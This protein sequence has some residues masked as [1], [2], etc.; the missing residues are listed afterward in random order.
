MNRPPGVADDECPV[1]GWLG[2]MNGWPEARAATRFEN[3]QLAEVSADRTT[4]TK[5]DPWPDTEVVYMIGRH[6]TVHRCE[7]P[8]CHCR[9]SNNEGPIRPVGPS[10]QHYRYCPIY[11]ME[12]P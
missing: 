6:G 9:D 12:T 3:L 11:E 4:L 10:E 8:K 7:V 1:C 2:S 5:P